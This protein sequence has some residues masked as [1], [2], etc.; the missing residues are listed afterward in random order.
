MKRAQKVDH[1]YAEK[2]TYCGCGRIAR[3]DSD[4]VLICDKCKK[5][6]GVKNEKSKTRFKN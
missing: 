3:W 6:K 2:Y 1:T 4:G 5:K